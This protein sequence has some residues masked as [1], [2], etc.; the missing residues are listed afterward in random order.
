MATI[1][2]AVCADGCAP[3]GDDAEIMFDLGV[4]YLTAT[5]GKTIVAVEAHKW[6]NLA[7]LYGHEGAAEARANLAA[8]MT[9]AQIAAAQR[10]ARNW[11][12]SQPTAVA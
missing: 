1:A 7:A 8:E 6:L 3:G 11:L 4:S 2:K 5:G 12:H 10:A 9:A